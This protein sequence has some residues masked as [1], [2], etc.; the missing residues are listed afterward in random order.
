MC[1]ASLGEA[2]QNCFILVQYKEYLTTSM[3]LDEDHQNSG[4]IYNMFHEDFCVSQ[5]LFHV[6]LYHAEKTEPHNY[7]LT[8]KLGH[9]QVSVKQLLKRAYNKVIIQVSVFQEVLM[10]HYLMEGRSQ[11]RMFQNRWG[12]LPL[13]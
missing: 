10:D 12:R 5:G 11:A 8:T 2:R 13:W 6:K 3:K 4:D 1:K 9:V 7:E